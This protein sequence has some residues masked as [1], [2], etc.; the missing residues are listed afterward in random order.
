[1][2][3]VAKGAK[4]LEV[5]EGDPLFLFSMARGKTRPLNIFY[6]EGCSHC[7]FKE[8][9]PGGE[10]EARM[11]RKGP[12][13]L[14]TVGA[15]SVTVRDEWACLIDLVN[16]NK[17]VLQGPSVDKITAD[18]PSL[19]L[20]EAETDLKGDKPSNRRLQKLKVPT[21]AGGSTDIL[22]GIK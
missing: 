6:D 1:M 11:T 18:F 5:P 8:G 4:V 12:M 10:L 13:T 3:K 14:G 16:G 19:K 7:V 2:K 15:S 20:S 17:Q 21:Q 9:V 22:L